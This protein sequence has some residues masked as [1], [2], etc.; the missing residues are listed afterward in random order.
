MKGYS[1]GDIASDISE[2]KS[3]I[4]DFK[5]IKIWMKSLMNKRI[6]IKM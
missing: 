4:S 5:Q 3:E 1:A 2:T 6:H